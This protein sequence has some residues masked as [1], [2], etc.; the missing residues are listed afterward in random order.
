[1]WKKIT[2]VIHGITIS[3]K[4]SVKKIIKHIFSG[5]CRCYMIHFRLKEMH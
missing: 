5:L 2:G 3:S 4:K 1:M